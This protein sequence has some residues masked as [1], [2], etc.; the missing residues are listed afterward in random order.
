MPVITTLAAGSAKA[1]GSMLSTVNRLADPYYNYNTLLIKPKTSDPLSLNATNNNIFLDSSSNNAVVSRFNA[2]GM[3]QTTFA[4]FKQKGDGWSASFNGTTD[5]LFTSDASRYNVPSGTGFTLQGWAYPLSTSGPLFVYGASRVAYVAD[6]AIIV[7]NN[8]VEIVIAGGGGN[9]TQYYAYFPTAML[10]NQWNHWAVVRSTDGTTVTA[11]LNG[12]PGVSINAPGTI[13]PYLLRGDLSGPLGIYLGIGIANWTAYS[14]TYFN[15]R[16]SN[17]RYDVGVSLYNS[18]FTPP[19]TQLEAI[20]QTVYLSCKS[21]IFKDESTFNSSISPNGSVSVQPFNPFAPTSSYNPGTVG[22]SA[23]FNGTGGHLTIPYTDAIGN[24]NESGVDFTVE[25][26][27]YP[28]GL[29]TNPASVPSLIG[30]MDQGSGTNYWSFGPL[31]DGT[32]RLYYFNGG[33][34]NVSSTER[35]KANQWNHIAFTKTTSG[36]SMFVNGVGTSPTAVSGTP[37]FSGSFPITIG[38]Y[39]N[40][41]F[42]NGYVGG[43]RIVKGEAL[44]SGTSYTV[45]TTPFTN[46]STTKLLLL[47]RNFA[48]A[49]Y[50]GKTTIFT[51]SAVRVNSVITVGGVSSI[52]F[53]GTTNSISN[54]PNLTTNYFGTGDFTIEGWFYP[55]SSPSTNWIPFLSIGSGGA[56]GREIRLAQNLN[57]AGYGY[58]IPNNTNNGDI[59]VPLGSLPANT[60]HHIAL[61]RLGSTVTLYKNGLSIFANT[62]VSF[63]FNPSSLTSA[64]LLLGHSPYGSDGV[65]RGIANQIR[66]TQGLARYSGNFTPPQISFVEFSRPLKKPTS[67]ELLMVGGGGSGGVGGPTTYESGGGGGGGLIY[68]PNWTVTSNMTVTVGGG[69][70]SGA[71]GTNTTIVTAAAN[72]TAIGGGTGS[73]DGVA[74]SGG[75][76]GGGAHAGTPGANGV[77]NSESSISSDSRLYGFGNRGGNGAPSRGGGGGGAGTAGG[78]GGAGIGGD[79]LQYTQF[80]PYGSPG[81]NYF[82]GGGGGGLG[83]PGA[84]GLGGGGSVA[85]MGGGGNGT[86]GPAPG[87]VGQTGGS[88]VVIMRYPNSFDPIIRT[89]AIRT[90]SNGFHLYAFTSTGRIDF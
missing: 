24:W 76:G 15:G 37:Q 11:Y 85:N 68:I 81:T 14:P 57:G 5:Y 13:A 7:Y 87:F 75:S 39:N 89:T 42:I 34:V 29:A 54:T 25:A 50:T 6:W 63:N 67:V 21:N 72:L 51:G 8:L 47:F 77:Q 20:S 83:S 23:F 12:S 32:L 66:I 45:P 2:G 1:Y 18:S 84:A 53:D 33:G 55:T 59:Y 62:G 28:M 26:F 69:G 71:R 48:V 79:G 10:L 65:Y 74:G 80:A 31:N 16:I 90:E 49:D 60:L 82:A 88:G 19:T 73:V 78:P 46:T 56:S 27:F 70:A 58:I 86:A 17:V 43:I 61:V 9:G 3:T 38:R 52:E 40:T 30:N 4:P 36:V 35:I 64:P 41:S 44:Y 22:T